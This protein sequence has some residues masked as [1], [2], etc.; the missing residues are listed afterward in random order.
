MDTAKNIVRGPIWPLRHARAATD[1]SA[2][3]LGSS[4]VS[5]FMIASII[6][7]IILDSS[8]WIGLLLTL[9]PLIDLTWFWPFFQYAGQ[10]VNLQTLIGLG[11]F[12]SNCILLLSRTWDARL[13]KRVFFF[14]ALAT[15]S[16]VASPSSLGLNE[17]L[18]LLTGATFFYSA[19][20]Y[21]AQMKRFKRFA[22]LVVMVSMIPVFLGFLQLLGLV[23]YFYW[24][25]A[26]G[27]QI[28]RVSGGYP[29]PLS[30][31]YLLIYACPL[32]LYLS[33]GKT[34]SAFTKILARSFLGASAVVL[35]FTYHRAGYIVIALE[36]LIWLYLAR[37]TKAAAALLLVLVLGAIFS[38]HS[39]S[40]L[41]GQAV[42]DAGDVDGEFLRGRGFQWYLFINSY[43][44]SGPFHWI[45]GNGGSVI[46]DLDP[47]LTYVLSPEEPHNDFIRIL[48]AYGLA[49]L[50][51]YLSILVLFF[52]KCLQHLR[53][54]NEFARDL[55]SVVLPM[56]V[57]VALLS[58]TTE[59]TRYPSGVWY[60]F[61]LGGAL[62]CVGGRSA[63][64]LDSPVI[65]RIS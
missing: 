41:Y 35:V 38:F 43:V 28:G 24:D 63:N 27:L 15:L 8:G 12:L 56:L 53:S 26:N 30:F 29:T 65:E 34:H 50:V 14:L 16:V 54:A 59:P 18:R 57:A 64:V 11:A 33:S 9:K 2:S 47:N 25:W 10:E 61:A 20:N 31:I 3:T 6:P 45:F 4:I 19:G 48:H 22:F 37:G 58:M 32:A 5:I 40:S 23:P 36:C 39:L 13:P 49:G 62:F 60:L 7:G 55:G 51:A 52:R 42:S 46:A 44:S 17:L 1:L 21:L